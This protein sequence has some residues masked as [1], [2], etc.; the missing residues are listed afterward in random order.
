MGGIEVRFEWTRGKSP[1]TSGR[2]GTAT[3]RRASV[4]IEAGTGLPAQAEEDDT[5]TI[6]SNHSK[7]SLTMSPAGGQTLALPSGSARGRDGLAAAATSD[8]SVSPQRTLDGYEDGGNESDPEDSETPWTCT[9]HIYPSHM[10]PLSDLDVKERAAAAAVQ[11]GSGL[12]ADGRLRLRLANLVP[13]PHHPK[14]LVQFKMPFPLPDVAITPGSGFPP[15]SG[16]NAHGA[17][18]YEAGVGARFLPRTLSPDGSINHAA[19]AQMNVATEILFTAEDIKDVVS[20][21]GLWLVV[22]EGF[23]GLGRTKRKGDGWHIRA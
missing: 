2:P 9:L 1:S 14:I 8:R 7:G 22:R 23:G 6:S 5:T 21:T 11:G 12:P 18:M 15:A 3:G 10:S 20:S 13:T 19:Q 16:V 17:G 4:L